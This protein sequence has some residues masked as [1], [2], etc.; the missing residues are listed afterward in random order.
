MVLD[1]Y[2]SPVVG[3]DGQ[4]YGR[5]WAFRNIT[6]HKRAEQACQESERKYRAIFDSFL[7][8]YFQAEIDGTILNVSPSVLNFCG[9]SREEVI[10]TSTLE[11]KPYTQAE[12][13]FIWNNC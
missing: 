10:G 3:K 8:L 6:D 11:W 2:T 12:K 1:R 4:Y 5:I 13:N 9:R 7:D